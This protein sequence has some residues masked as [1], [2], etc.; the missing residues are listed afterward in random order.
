MSVLKGHA[1]DAHRDR[2]LHQAAAV[3]IQ[4]AK[5]AAGVMKHKYRVYDVSSRTNVFVCCENIMTK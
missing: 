4:L 1:A 2:H 3:W 5:H